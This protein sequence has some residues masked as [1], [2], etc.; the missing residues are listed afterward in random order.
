MPSCLSIFEDNLHNQGSATTSVFY[1]SLCLNAVQDLQLRLS[2]GV[3]NHNFGLGGHQDLPV[4]GK[5]FGVL[6]VST[7]TGKLGYICAFSGKL[8]GSNQHKGFVPPVFDMLSKGSFLNTGMKRLNELNR[9]YKLI[10]PAGFSDQQTKESI[11]LERQM[12]SRALQ[13]QLFESYMIQN[14]K[15]ERKSILQIFSEAGY[16]NPPAGA[17]EC[18]APKL[19]QYAFQKKLSPLWMKEFW[20]GESPKSENWIHREF[21]PSCR[22]KCGPIL[23]FMLEPKIK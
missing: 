6:L 7:A 11:S 19:Y 15:G 16:R 13:K 10:D 2:N 8:A 20:W 21:Y 1:N 12:L 9:I 14:Y 23:S 17:G 4:I 5:M 3:E 22:E 18:A